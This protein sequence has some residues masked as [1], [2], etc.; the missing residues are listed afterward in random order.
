MDFVRSNTT[1]I[2]MRP[3]YISKRQKIH[4]CEY[5]GCTEFFYTKW[6]I[7]RHY[8]EHFGKRK[9]Q[10]TQQLARFAGVE[11]GKDDDEE[12]EKEREEEGV[13]AN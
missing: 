2:Q 9:K 12:D 10:V 8:L 7:K 4:R 1:Y 6:E 13:K 5:R 11:S 3:H